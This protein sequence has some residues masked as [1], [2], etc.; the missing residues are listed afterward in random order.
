[1]ERETIVQT[2]LQLAE[3][4][5]A[6]EVETYFLDRDN[7]TIEV[8]GGKLE[9]LHRSRER[10]LG[11][12]VVKAGSFGYAFTSDLGQAAV[13]DTVELAVQGAKYSS[14]DSG[15]SL[16]TPASY[17]RSLAQFDG[18]IE[19]TPL[20]AKLDLALAIEQ[21]ALNTDTRITKSERA[22]YEENDYT[23]LLAN[24]HGLRVSYRANFCGGYVWVVAE[25]N[26][27]VQTGSGL[28]YSTQLAQ[29]DPVA[30]GQEAALEAVR[31]LGARPIKTQKLA[32][33]LP[34]QVAAQFLGIL[35]TAL[36]AEAVQKGRSLFAD[37][38]DKQMAS[39]V[40]TI[41]DDG[42]LVGGINTAPTDG[43]G[44]PSER[45]ILVENGVLR[46]FLHNSYTAGKEET[47]STGNGVRGSF[48]T[49]PEVGPTNMFFRPGTASEEELIQSVDQGLYVFDLM[50]AHTANPISGDFSLGATGLLIEQGKLTRPVRQVI[51]AGNIQDMLNQVQA[52][53][54]NLRF[55]LGFGSPAL[56]VEPLTISGD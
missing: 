15:A 33:V 17:D 52:V 5:G 44:V 53:A 34:P 32:L 30:I 45:T 2:G 38:I 36:T 28:S 3:K 22:A 11:I 10:G 39:P 31:L 37:Q 29:I 7:L 54:S 4:A 19:E 46:T 12:R 41:I 51:L 55:Y 43:E 8:R 21:A 16:P 24:S 14:L 20:E 50:G 23:V 56:L 25:A 27:D 9:T 13:A 1:M 49:T 47:V 6:D 18:K 42:S 48:K 35:A 40:V 26:G